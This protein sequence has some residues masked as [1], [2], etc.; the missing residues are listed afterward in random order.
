[1][2]T[3]ATTRRSPNPWWIATVAGMASYLD[4]AAIVSTGTALV[5]FQAEFGFDA[6]TF[7]VL[8]ALLTGMIA[9][10]ALL[11]GRLGDRFGRK[12]VFMITLTLF[13]IGALL[14]VLA[15]G[16]TM[17]FAG[18]I[19]LGFAVGADLPV[20]MAMISESAPEGKRGKMITFSHILWMVGIVAVYVLGL[21]VGG[22]G[23]TGARIL[24]GHL[25]IVG[26]I[27]LLLRLSLPESKAWIDARTAAITTPIKTADGTLKQLFSRQYL[28]VLIG[29]ALFY[30]L[31]NIAANTNGQFST[32]IFVDVAGSDVQTASLISLITLPVSFVGA[33]IMIRIVDTK[34][35][36][37]IFAVAAVLGTLTF[38][39]PVFFGFSVLT[40]AIVGIG[41]ALAG[42]I[43]G[44]PMYKIWSQE[45]FPTLQRA[46]AQGATT[47]FTRVVA[48][49]VALFTPLIIEVGP[50][51]L[52]IFMA[53][54][55]AAAA[56]IGIF[57]LAKVPKAV[58]DLVADGVETGTSAGAAAASTGGEGR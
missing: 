26:I 2:T 10:G 41:Y 34:Y 1:M 36:M 4:A 15:S 21:F 30:S 20:S 56:L 22:M 57:W 9:V 43:A 39:I 46:S 14:L 52:Y 50:E 37:P 5:L 19:V 6:V 51:I 24:Y 7:G 44:E 49:V 27:V 58:D 25:V 35:R 18:I 8:S 17:L 53:I 32:K 40:L 42:A 38:L 33:A 11:G 47:A 12:S 13:V 3:N 28:P 29:T 23:A 45:L 55:S 16:T 48:A 54:T 31:A